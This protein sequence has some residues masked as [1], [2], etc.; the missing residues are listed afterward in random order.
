M[1]GLK[2]DHCGLPETD[3]KR[4]LAVVITT[5]V[6]DEGKLHSRHNWKA[7]IVNGI[8]FV[9]L[10]FAALS[11]L[12]L[13]AQT[14]PE[15][16]NLR[17]HVPSL[18]REALHPAPAH[19]LRRAEQISDPESV[20]LGRRAGTPI[21]QLIYNPVD[22]FQVYQPVLLPGGAVDHTIDSKGLASTSVIAP[23]AKDPETCAE[24]VIV[25]HTF[26]S[27]YGGEF[28]GSY[29]PPTCNFN[30]VVLN[31]TV[32]SIG[33]QYDRL[34]MIY[35]SDTEIWRTS[36]EEPTKR[37]IKW[38]HIKDSSEHLALWKQSQKV[39]FDLPNLV[40]ENFTGPYNTT[41]TATFFQSTAVAAK[42][43]DS[44][45]A[46]TAAQSSTGGASRWQIPDDSASKAV[47]FPQN[48]NRAVFSVA[49]TGQ[50]GEEFWWSNIPDSTVYT[51]ND[52]TGA[53]SGG[54]AWREVQVLIDGQLAGVVWPFPV[55]FTGGISPNLWSPIVG[56]ETFDLREH[57]IDITPWLPVLCDGKQH[58]FTIYV[59][60]LGDNGK[61]SGYVNTTTLSNWLVT[62][63]IF[64]WLDPTGSV[65][66]GTKP[67]ISAPNPSIAISSKTTQNKTSGYNETLTTEVTVS[68][69][70]S[71]SSTVVTKNGSLTSTWSQSLSFSNSQSFLEF[72]NIQY[73]TQSTKGTDSATGQTAY[74]NTYSYPLYSNI[75]ITTVDNTNNTRQ[76]TLVN[77]GLS[78]QVEGTSIYPTG[79]EP[80]TV[81]PKT[82]AV[83]SAASGSILDTTSKHNS[84][85]V[86]NETGFVV[87]SYGAT[88]QKLSFG[89]LAAAVK[90][91]LYNQYNFAV[92]YSIA[93]HTE[94][95][96][97][98]QISDYTNAT[99]LAI[100]NANQ[101][102]AG[103]TAKRGAGGGAVGGGEKRH[104][105]RS[106]PRGKV[107]E[108][109]RV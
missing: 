1:E 82:A 46:I 101:P 88:D 35:L 64:V 58:T 13:P 53:L 19:R 70:F 77:R 75:T 50:G 23:A 41:V 29:T 17:R 20:K 2:L 48:A 4:A 34:G 11:Y 91:E 57:E 67:T 16:H 69:T 99:A 63:K 54:S 104:L 103:S 9:A 39:I 106:F 31:L 76:D 59:A 78:L 86:V 30:R 74:K 38:T 93:R 62:G 100:G 95:V 8:V 28:V 43:A 102:A 40:N 27:S 90:T 44:I 65:T 83:A 87:D 89:A 10:V 7:H 32:T 84:Y 51:F 109:R 42:P 94:A 24:I 25:D 21:S 60:N 97:G 15:H 14:T 98:A 92:N 107:H 37:G 105:V 56:I 6:E 26:Y 55:I 52:T 96:F 66:T 79:L 81:V 12:Q 108:Q 36:T 85:L 3:E 22:A 61:G 47:S 72:G 68:R 18:E 71:V 73:S 80:W 33:R 49:A 45:I 5:G